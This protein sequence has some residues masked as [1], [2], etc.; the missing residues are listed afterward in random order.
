MKTFQG[1]EW[2]DITAMLVTESDREMAREA[3]FEGYQKCGA[4]VA[5]CMELTV[6]QC[7]CDLGAIAGCKARVEA[8]ATAIA[9]ARKI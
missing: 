8:L 1:G 7:D 6:R 3:L 2:K 4:N 5:N 9:T